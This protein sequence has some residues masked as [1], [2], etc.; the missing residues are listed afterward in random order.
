VAKKTLVGVPKLGAGGLSGGMEMQPEDRDDDSDRMLRDPRE[1]TL[2]GREFL[3]LFARRKLTK[4]NR[5]EMTS[6][7]QRLDVALGKRTG[8]TMLFLASN[9]GAGASSV[10]YGYA[11]LSAQT[12]ERRT[13]IIEERE[14][15]DDEW[16]PSISVTE[17]FIRGRRFTETAQLVGRNLYRNFLVSPGM[18]DRASSVI[19]E[20]DFWK[21]LAGDFDEVVFDCS[22]ASESQMGLVLSSRATATVVVVEAETTQ[23]RVMQKLLSDLR[24]FQANVV[25]TVLNKRQYHIPKWIYR[26]L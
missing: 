22:A 19:A 11:Q 7:I 13:L 26:H 5:T 20:P 1:T 3:E 23:K 21:A 24:M 4:V 2:N 25:G 12:S 15:D 14:P 17:S 18:Q 6:L 10:A 8:R 9:P 16:A